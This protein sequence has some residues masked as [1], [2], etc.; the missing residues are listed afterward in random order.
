MTLDKRLNFKRHITN[1]T[2]NFKKA[3]PILRPRVGENSKLSLGNRLL[4]YKSKLR[5]LISYASPF[6]SAAANMH[7]IGLE[8]IQSITVRQ[9]ARQAWYIGNRNIRKDLRLLTIQEYF[10]SIAE[11]FFKKVD[12]ITNAALLSIPS[13]DPLRE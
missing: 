12:G 5:P 7:L 3:K 11:K 1:V 10:K 9:I 8:R 6:W 2:K 13:F 4:L